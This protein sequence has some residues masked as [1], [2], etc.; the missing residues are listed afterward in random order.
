MLHT[1][2]AVIYYFLVWWVLSSS[3]FGTLD[4]NY[5]SLKT[6][7]VDCAIDPV[8]GSIATSTG[9]F[10][11]QL[12]APALLDQGDQQKTRMFSRKLE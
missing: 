1:H 3:L 10:G 2:K 11:W 4:Y 9:D 12:V 5:L 7:S 8:S 6:S